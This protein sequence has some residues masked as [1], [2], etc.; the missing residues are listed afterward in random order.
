MDV[1]V[2]V[3]AG[4]IGAAVALELARAGRNVVVVDKAGG[5]GHGSTSSSSAVVRFNFSTRAGVATAWESLHHWQHWGEYLACDV[6]E[7]V[8]YE[9]CGLAMLDVELAPRSGYVRLFDEVGVPYEE[10]DGATLRRRIP[11]ID[12]GRYWPPRRID[13]ERFWDDAPG[14]LGAVYTPDAGYVGDPQLAARNL[15]AAASHH[16]AQFRLRTRVT[17]LDTDG[18]RVTG[19]RL[20][21]G[22]TIACRTVV[23]AAGP[24]SGAL[25]A[26]A[27]VGADF[28]V[29]VRPLRQEVAY[30]TAP[31]GFAAPGSAGISIADMDLGTYMRGE[32]GGGL[33]IGGTEPE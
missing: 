17:G 1:D 4:V 25:N 2:V 20:D 16:G 24:W 9:R 33:L 3:G 29:G 27:G 19:V 5:V 21:D 12:S 26:L 23:N 15:A 31:A 14:E 11:G 18:G 22:S 7:L 10:W 28:T 6:G 30:A 8:R 13:D 32:V